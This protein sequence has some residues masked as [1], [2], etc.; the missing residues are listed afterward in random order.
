MLESE[1][2]TLGV[3]TT[4]TTATLA[5]AYDDDAVMSTVHLSTASTST[6]TSVEY[7]RVQPPPTPGIWPPISVIA[8]AASGEAT[9]T[10]ISVTPFGELSRLS[11]SGASLLYETEICARDSQGRITDRRE[12]LPATPTGHG[13]ATLPRFVFHHFEYDAAGRLHRERGYSRTATETCASWLAFFASNPL[14]RADLADQTMAYTANGGL[15][16]GA[17]T[18]CATFDAADRPICRPSRSYNPR[19]QLTSPG[20]GDT[21]AYDVLGRIRS[22]RHG[23]TRITYDWDPASRLVHIGGS[24]TGEEHFVYDGARAVAWRRGNDTSFFV[25]GSM[26]HVPDVMCRDVGTNGSIDETYRL[27]TDERGS[28]RLVVRVDGATAGMVAQRID[29]DAWGFPSFVSGDPRMQPFGFAGGTWLS[30][31]GLW[32][33]GARDYDPNI[34]AWTAGD[35][36]GFEGG[37]NVYRYCGADPV[38]CIDPSGMQGWEE[39][40][41]IIFLISFGA[42]APSDTNFHSDTSDHRADIGALS[43]AVATMGLGGTVTSSMSVTERQ[44][45]ARV[46]ASFFGSRTSRLGALVARLAGGSRLPPGVTTR[47]LALYRQFARWAVLRG[48][49]TMG[50]QAARAEAIDR[51]IGRDVVDVLRDTMCGNP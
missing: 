35:P 9:T 51:I 20:H 43:L 3:G 21:V 49:D 16:S 14:A 10:T 36:I 15:L 34:G 25:Y 30:D 32:R 23:G 2:I 44:L 29:Y 5:Y 24:G 39:A 7:R 19:G 26:G 6:T 41:A 1:Q 27:V 22:F 38:N 18:R 11:T 28:V 42:N 8:T 45:E 17:H 50:I 13:S 37:E 46:L 33:F 48:R 12:L 40:A 47:I 31:A 4:S